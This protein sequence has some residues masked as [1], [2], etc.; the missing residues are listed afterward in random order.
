[1]W[2]LSSGALGCARKGGFL[3]TMTK[4]QRLPSSMPEEFAELVSGW[5]VSEMVCL[6]H[7]LM[8]KYTCR[9]SSATK[10]W[11][12]RRAHHDLSPS[13][14]SRGALVADQTLRPDTITN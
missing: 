4:V 9:K 10:R 3:Q 14:S 6:T 8:L 11:R 13:S 5:P 1:M 12:N 7:V 2:F